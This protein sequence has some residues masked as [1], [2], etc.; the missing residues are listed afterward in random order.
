MA[1]QREQMGA[2]HGEEGWEVWEIYKEEKKKKWKFKMEMLYVKKPRK[3]KGQ[4]SWCYEEVKGLSFQV[5]WTSLWSLYP[6]CLDFISNSCMALNIFIHFSLYTPTLQTFE[7][8]WN[9]KYSY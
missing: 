1:M 2:L 4:V 9:K 5:E 8:V 6:L 3:G 7:N